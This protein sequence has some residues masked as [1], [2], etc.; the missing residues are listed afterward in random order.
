[1]FIIM[2]AH[3]VMMMMTTKV[4]GTLTTAMLSAR[5][6]ASPEQ[7]ELTKTLATL[8]TAHQ[9]EFSLHIVGS[10]APVER[11]TFLIVRVTLLSPATVD[12]MESLMVMQILLESDVYTGELCYFVF[13][14]DPD[15]IG[16]ERY[17]YFE[18]NLLIIFV[19][20]NFASMTCTQ[21]QQKLT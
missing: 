5:C 15:I 17:M 12:K 21:C 3:S 10:S 9:E 8:A 6:W 11:E 7:Q 1:M 19:T 2:A 14:C 16:V 4:V 18:N 13:P 20:F